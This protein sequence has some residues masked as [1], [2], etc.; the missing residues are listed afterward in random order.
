MA[1]HTDTALVAFRAA[2]LAA[3]RD[4]GTQTG[5]GSE[6]DID[7]VATRCMCSGVELLMALQNDDADSLAQQMGW[8]SAGDL[9]EFLERGP[10]T[11]RLP[12]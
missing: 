10:D 2:T 4:A 6:T 11:M 8:Q 12:Q 3:T 9:M 1:M 7:L 5:P